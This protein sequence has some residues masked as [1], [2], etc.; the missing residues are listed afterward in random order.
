MLLHPERLISGLAA[1]CELF[2]VVK[3]VR[4][5]CVERRINRNLKAS[6]WS[7][8]GVILLESSEERIA[9]QRRRTRFKCEPAY[10]N[11]TTSRIQPPPLHVFGKRLFWYLASLNT[12]R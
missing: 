6:E 10:Q 9:V 3:F 2:F 12:G 7:T 4:G 8:A 5:V 11:V 1:R